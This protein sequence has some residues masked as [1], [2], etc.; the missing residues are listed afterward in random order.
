MSKKSNQ[1]SKSSLIRFLQ[2]SKSLYLY[3]HH[4]NLRSIPDVKQQQKFDRGIRIGKLAQELFPNG[5]DCTPPS[6]F[7]Y[8]QSISATSLLISQGQKVIY[9][10]AFK[11]QG[12][13]IA[14]DIL[15]QDDGKFYAYEV[16]SSLGISNTYI[17]DCAI[18]YYIISKSGIKL[19]DFFIVHVNEKYVMED[20]L[21][22]HQ[23]FAKQSVLKQILAEQEFIE[24][25]I[26]EAIETIQ[27]PNMPDVKIGGQ[28]NKPYPC[29][30]KKYC[31]KD[32]PENSIWN[33]QGMPLAEKMELIEN[34]VKT[35]DEYALLQPNNVLLNAYTTKAPIVDT[36]KIKTI[37]AVVEYPIA[38]FDIE[39]FQSAIPIFKHTKPYERIPFLFSLHTQESSDA[40][41]KHSYFLSTTDKD[42]R[43]N[44][45]LKFLDDTKNINSI[46]VFNELME[47]GMLNYLANL[48]PQYRTE[49]AERINKIVDIEVVFKNLYYY[50]PNQLGSYSLKT[51][52]GVTL[53]NNPY[54]N[55]N[56]KDGVEAMALYN[57]LFYKSEIEKKQ[58]YNELI[59]YCST[60]TLALFLIY[61]FLQKL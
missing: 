17:L 61:Q 37:L 14:L 21:D 4:Y 41:L 19:E 45:L 60:D 9:E 23:F 35:I 36:E 5:K 24:Q 44:F 34:N 27:L 55:I 40:P 50:H 33:L 1:L 39:A 12:I 15:V 43:L 58:T 31:W 16:K 26:N 32:V 30:F 49:I 11:Y 59:E 2:C 48:F 13:V 52:A 20:S 18:Q 8:A 25:K 6:P 10:A 56:V 42:D 53:K 57:E 3:K 22:I 29:D 47:K 7:Q 54:Q 46:L 28:C 51:I 38:V